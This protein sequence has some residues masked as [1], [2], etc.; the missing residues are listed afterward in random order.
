MTLKSTSEQQALPKDLMMHQTVDRQAYTD[1]MHY[2][3]ILQSLYG[4]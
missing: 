4:A 1:H 2:L 3:E